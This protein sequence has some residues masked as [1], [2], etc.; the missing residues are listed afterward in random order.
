MTRG[1]ARIIIAILVITNFSSLA[2]AA[3]PIAGSKCSKVGQIAST[4]TKK[5]TC[6]KSGKKL[7]WNKGVAIKS[8]V[9]PTPESTAIANPTPT[10][11]PTAMATPT[12]TP[13]TPQ[14][15]FVTPNPAVGGYGITWNNITSKVA[16]ISAAA[17]IDSQATIKRNQGLP[18]ASVSFTTYISPAAAA[19]DPNTAEA[20]AALRKTFALFAKFPAA[21]KVFFVALNQKDRVETQKYLLSIYP[22]AAFINRTIDQMY[23][24]DSNLPAGSVFTVTECQGA[25]GG[26][27]T[28]LYRTEAEAAAVIWGVC[29]DLGRFE[30][31]PHFEAV[32]GMAHEY[33][34]TLQFAFKPGTPDGYANIPCWMREGEPEWGQTAAAVDFNTYLKAQHFHPYRLTSDGLKYEDTFARTWSAEEVYTYLSGSINVTACGQTNLYAYSYSLGAAATEA[35]VSVAGSE[36][37]FALHERIIA[38]VDYN[39][40]FNDI[41]GISWEKALPILSEVVA[42]KITK[43]WDADALTYQTRPG[44]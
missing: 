18:N 25:S 28:F 37:I 32:Q 31:T 9:R 35:L 29:P 17:W 40:A 12:P 11:T 1:L 16:D 33:I 6:I 20:E 21:K 19:I 26:R 38:G 24:I 34:H 36:S 8:E 39:T 13:V 2:E 15:T 10:P 23:G 5:F 43:S 30:R 3:T 4:A 41:F 22:D 42:K 27:N 14:K 44:A 7:I